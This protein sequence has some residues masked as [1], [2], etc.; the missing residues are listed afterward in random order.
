MALPYTRAMVNAA[1]EGHLDDVPVRP[2]PVFQVLV[3]T[4]VPGVPAN[5]LDARG[6][7]KDPQAYDRT[8]RELSTRFRGNFEKFGAVADDILEAAPLVA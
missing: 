3:P 1:I 7:W 6:L 4:N 8:A 2:H 5:L